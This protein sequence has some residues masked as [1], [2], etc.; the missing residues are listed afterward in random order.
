ML[1]KLLVVILGYCFGAFFF[2]RGFLLAR[3]T[4]RL[5]STCYEVQH[6]VIA[7]VA[8]G[9]WVPAS[10][11]RSILVIVDALRYD[12]VAEQAHSK[13]VYHNRFPKVQRLLN[14]ATQHAMLF[15][16]VA[17]P[18]TTTLQRLKGLTTGSLPTFVDA[19]SNFAGSAIEEDNIIDQLIAQGRKVVFMGDDTWLSLF[20]HQFTKAFP[21]PSFDVHDLHT[22]DNGVLAHL[23]KEIKSNDWDVLIAHFLGVDH[24]GHKYGPNHPQMARKLSQMDDMIKNVTELMSPDTILF[25]FGDHGMTQTGDHGG[26]SEEELGAAL[27]AYSTSILHSETENVRRITGQLSL[28]PTLA[29]LL[30][31]PIPF[32]NLGAFIPELFKDRDV[33][34]QAARVNFY[35][36]MRY[37]ETY[38][39]NFHDAMLTERLS[40][41][42]KIFNGLEPN[43][44]T[45][46][47]SIKMLSRVGA[48][49]L[50]CWAKYHLGWILLGILAIL[51]TILSSLVLIRSQGSFGSGRAVLLKFVHFILYLWA[52]LARNESIPPI[53]GI[54]L[55]MEITV[56][57]HQLLVN[58]LAADAVFGMVDFVALV[59]LILHSVAVFSNSYI[60]NDDLV[61][62]YF[63]KTLLAVLFIDAIRHFSRDCS[64]GSARRKARG[65]PRYSLTFLVSVFKRRRFGLLPLLLGNL[66]LLRLSALFRRCREEIPKCSMSLFLLPFGSLFDDQQRLLRV[67]VAS[68]SLLLLFLVPWRYLQAVGC[69]NVGS[70]NILLLKTAFQCLSVSV[71]FSWCYCW[72]TELYPKMLDNVVMMF[73]PRVCYGISLLFL[74]MFAIDP[75][76][77]SSTTLGWSTKASLLSRYEFGALPKLR[78][79]QTTSGAR[80]KLA[81]CIFDVPSAISRSLVLVLW[82]LYFI[83]ALLL[84][85]G[86]CASVTS[87]ML[88]SAS[89]LKVGQAGTSEFSQVALSVELASHF[90]YAF[91][92]QPTFTAIPWDAAFIGVPGNFKYMWVQAALVF[93]NISASCILVSLALPLMI[94]W[95]KGRHEDE[96]TAT[97]P[98]A[99]QDLSIER[100]LFRCN[101]LFL[102]AI[103]VKLL[104]CTVACAIHRRHLMMWK[105]FAPKLVFEMVLFFSS[106]LAVLCQYALVIRI[107][108]RLKRL[109]R[110]FEPIASRDFLE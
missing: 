27:F 29:M 84:G 2:C 34:L 75:L 36:V 110:F 20:P 53:V 103:G 4:L 47:K 9:C 68:A 80:E 49:F 51:E 78:H 37:M 54:T 88:V 6:P 105:I 55:G 77:V 79:M 69:F 65:R 89:F 19:G 58:L 82:M 94:R 11:R 85:D 44:L 67:T 45:V 90:F 92:H 50:D 74:A 106:C 109:L 23:Y 102:T 3:H 46:N 61:V 7:N 97:L 24:C 104:F 31:V 86:L 101:M 57:I 22:V 59:V 72:V 108:C 18:P 41:L 17:D 33:R 76:L 64:I 100:D 93:L 35:Q 63:L 95:K 83:L 81:L 1:L 91:G 99:E 15:K 71:F 10:Y 107:E 66:C 30:D 48:V 8:P 21:F 60:I 28:V 52:T 98:S 70:L 42:L 56:N 96:A 32:S 16:F 25:V 13:Q 43:E 26:D 5:K 87:L 38:L 12:F 62:Q 40:P 14:N 39:R 73:F